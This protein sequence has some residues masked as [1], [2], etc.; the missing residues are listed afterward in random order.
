MSCLVSAVAEVTVVGLAVVGLAVVGLAVVGL[1]VVGLAVVGLAVVGLAVVLGAGLAPMRTT[2]SKMA[3]ARIL[4]GSMAEYMA[5]STLTVIF[6]FFQSIFCFQWL[7]AI[8]KVHVG[9]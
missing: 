3:D 7:I 1:A 9:P 2:D 5:K 4:I 8:E 6:N